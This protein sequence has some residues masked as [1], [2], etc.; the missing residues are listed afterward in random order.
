MQNLSGNVGGIDAT[1]G[2][3]CGDSCVSDLQSHSESV[4]SDDGSTY[5][6]TFIDYDQDGMLSVGDTFTVRGAG[7]SFNGPAQDD[8]SLE[9]CFDINDEVVGIITLGEVAP[10]NSPTVVVVS[11]FSASSA[12]V[13]TRPLRARPYSHSSASWTMLP[14]NAS[15]VVP[16]VDLTRSTYFSLYWKGQVS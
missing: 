7:H 1:Y 14:T 15:M 9:V 13:A 8:W 11:Y 2:A 10:N 5:P 4:E 6:I 12:L 3:T 16:S